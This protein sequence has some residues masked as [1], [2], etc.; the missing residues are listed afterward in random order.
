M[1][2]LGNGLV[3]GIQWPPD[4]RGSQESGSLGSYLERLYMAPASRLRS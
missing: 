4:Y 1:G 3:T 2:Y